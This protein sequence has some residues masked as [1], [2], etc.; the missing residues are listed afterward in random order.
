VVVGGWE[1]VMAGERQAVAGPATAAPKAAG[2]SPA[3][4]WAPGSVSRPATGSGPLDGL[5]LAVKDMIFLEGHVSSFGHG[6][7]RETHEPSPTTAP[8]LARL[9][10]AG[11]SMAGLTKLDQ[12]AY[13]IIGNAGE[14]VAPLNPLYPERFTCGS[15]SGPAAAV[16]AGLADVGIGTDT[17]GSIR[18]PAAACGLFGLRPTH[19]LISAEGVLPLAPSF[20]VVGVLARDLA[21]LRQVMETLSSGLDASPADLAEDPVSRRLVVPVDCLAGV[22]AETSAAVCATAA[23][24][25]SAAGCELAEVELGAFVSDDVA[26][27]FARVQGRQVWSAHGPWLTQNAGVLAPDVAQRVARAEKLSAEPQSRQD[28]D[29]AAWHA[30]TAALAERLPADTIAVLPVMP[31]FP[32]LRTATAAE[33]QAFRIRALRYTAPASLAGR[34]ELVIPVRHVASDRQVGVGILGPAGS[35]LGL[36]SAASRVCPPRGPLEI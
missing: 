13:S 34:P 18:A 9:L 5:T 23:A 12:L 29:A 20:D 4:C 17:G 3:D 32:P 19:G 35:D 31:D 22:S 11:A 7:W 2:P 6:R 16:A 25:A 27:L 24:L 30:Y 36:I 15:S 26:D 21:P 8:V 33:L 1:A 10:A 14:G 28:A